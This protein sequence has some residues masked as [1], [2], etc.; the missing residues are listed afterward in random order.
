MAGA[1]F[2]CG[3]SAYCF[4]MMA[5]CTEPDDFL[6]CPYVMSRSCSSRTYICDRLTVGLP[7]SD[8]LSQQLLPDVVSPCF[9]Q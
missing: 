6:S 8:K 4:T 9:Y 1:H 3:F 2:I 7:V 5:L